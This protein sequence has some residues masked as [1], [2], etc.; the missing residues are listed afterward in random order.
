MSFFKRSGAYNLDCFGRIGYKN[1]VKTA[2]QIWEQMFFM[3]ASD[4]VINYLNKNRF[5]VAL[6]TLCDTFLHIVK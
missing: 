2:K 3:Q 1:D 6:S 5:F 4:F